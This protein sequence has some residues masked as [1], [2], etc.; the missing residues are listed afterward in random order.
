MDIIIITHRFLCHLLNFFSVK[1]VNTPRK[2]QSPSSTRITQSSCVS[3]HGGRWPFFWVLI[4]QELS[5]I[6]RQRDDD[7]R[8]CLRMAALA[9]RGDATCH[10]AARLEPWTRHSARPRRPFLAAAAW[11][12]YCVD[13]TQRHSLMSV[14]IL[15]AFEVISE[16]QGSACVEVSH[17]AFTFNAICVERL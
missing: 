11:R 6:Q 2:A 15:P 10:S 1:S 7:Q 5:I 13:M 4:F 3:S 17:L 8:A 12:Y 14:G 16:P 9:Q